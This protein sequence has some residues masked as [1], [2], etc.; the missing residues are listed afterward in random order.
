MASQLL[1]Q[2][3]KH[4]HDPVINLTYPPHQSSHNL[5][6]VNL[7][8]TAKD[9]MDSNLTCNVT[10]DGNL[11]YSSIPALNNSPVNVSSGT[12]TNGE[13]FWNVT[14]TD[15][16]LRNSTSQTWSFNITDTPPT[17]LLVWPADA[18]LDGDG[19][20][21][22]TFNATDNT[23]FR[24]CSLIINETYYTANQTQ[25]INGGNT[26]INKVGMQEGDYNWTV[27]CYDLSGSSNQPATWDL[28]IDLYY[29]TIDLNLP[30][31]TST[32]PTGDLNFNFTADD[33]YDST[34][35]CNLTI[36][37]IIEDTFTA[38]SGDLTNRLINGLTDGTK[39]WNVT[40]SDDAGHTN[41]SS[42][43]IVNVSEAPTVAL[44]T[45]NETFFEESAINLTYTP[46]DNTNLSS[47]SIYLNG[48]FNKSNE[49]LIL[50]NQPN[51]FTLNSLLDGTYTWF[52]NCSDFAGL[53]GQS[54]T[55]VFYY[56]VYC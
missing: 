21:S 13:H 3:T 38:T 2:R 39:R 7:S 12:L 22:F 55:R 14:C 17:V 11:L 10:L 6:E 29:P 27:I 50:N 54:E 20:V 34:L 4:E 5:N 41:T 25:I 49:T 23:G 36:E 53:E 48:A 43:W 51:N 30:S 9:N 28:G 40:C 1:R 56:C 16:A 24:N 31:N 42:T 47:C 45:A 52:V 46:S 8:F 15:E 32:S 37:G 18:S 33:T 26:V 44:N 35:D 19:D